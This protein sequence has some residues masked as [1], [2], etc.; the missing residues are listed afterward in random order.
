MTA[1]STDALRRHSALCG[2]RCEVGIR[3]LGLI[4][5]LS[6]FILPPFPLPLFLYFPHLPSFYL[7]FTPIV[8]VFLR[9]CFRGTRPGSCFV[10][11]N[12]S[13]LP[14]SRFGENVDLG[15]EID[16]VIVLRVLH[17]RVSASG[18][19]QKIAKRHWKLV[20]RR[21]GSCR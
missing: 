14:K 18:R 19:R 15:H 9:P 16:S 20:D 1:S 5:S 4:S 2:C 11:S 10:F 17:L 3:P 13:A 12:F 21:C 7:F 8:C 6:F